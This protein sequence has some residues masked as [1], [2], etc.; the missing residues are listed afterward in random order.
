MER[1]DLNEIDQLFE[2]LIWMKWRFFVV[3]WEI[4]EILTEL[5]DEFW[6]SEE[7]LS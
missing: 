6:E 1:R 3:I 7:V 2:V 5:R 4:W